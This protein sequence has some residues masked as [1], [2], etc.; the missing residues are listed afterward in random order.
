MEMKFKH[1]ESGEVFISG[2]P[3]TLGEYQYPGNWLELAS[4]SEIES[5]G[6]EQLP[7]DEPIFGTPVTPV[8]PS[9]PA[10]VT[11]FQALAAPLQ[12]GLLADVEA[13]M[14]LP[15]TDPFT[16]LAWK[17]AQG[18]RRDSPIVTEWAQ[19]LNLSA[20]QLDDLFRFAWTITG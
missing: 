15:E 1:K 19:V 16:V 9:V 3:F 5:L 10:F 17:E 2:V 20:T 6:L 7:P 14:A 12:A 8:I 4:A 18:F 11:R 13:Y